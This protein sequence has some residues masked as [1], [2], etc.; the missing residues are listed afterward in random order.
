MILD[1]LDALRGDDGDGVG[2]LTESPIQLHKAVRLFLGYLVDGHLN[3][4]LE[5]KAEC[6]ENQR[7]IGDLTQLVTGEFL[8]KGHLQHIK[9]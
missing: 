7:H 4:H 5:K 6:I 1:F 8:D 2:N 9:N 3:I